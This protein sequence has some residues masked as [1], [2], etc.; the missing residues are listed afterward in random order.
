[1]WLRGRAGCV[2]GPWVQPL[3]FKKITCQMLKRFCLW[4]LWQIAP[5]KR[6]VS[7]RAT[8]TYSKLKQQR[9]VLP[10]PTNENKPV[11]S[12]RGSCFFLLN[13]GFRSYAER[14][15]AA[16]CALCLSFTVTLVSHSEQQSITSWLSFVFQDTTIVINLCH[17]IDEIPPSLSSTDPVVAL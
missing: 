6:G 13:T 9:H 4:M 10:R 12:T 7:F 5:K 14:S 11:Y 17:L 16:R 3:A 1:M 15:G 2:Q 8:L